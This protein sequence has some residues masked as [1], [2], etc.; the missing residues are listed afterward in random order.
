MKKIII[1]SVLTFLIGGVFFSYSSVLAADFKPSVTIPGFFEA[2]QPYPIKGDTLGTYIK[3][4]YTF[5]VYAGSILAAVMILMAGYS[6]L[7]AGGNVNQIG[8]AKKMLGGALGGF[9]LLLTSWV[10]LNTI[11][12]DLVQFKPFNIQPIINGTSSAIEDTQPCLNYPND[13]PPRPTQLYSYEPKDAVTNC[14]GAVENKTC[15]C[16]VVNDNP[17]G[18]PGPM[19]TP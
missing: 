5:S 3:A 2:G 1:L 14:G 7:T 18:G 16:Q 4:I 17:G 8:Q 12:P 9:V 15:W 13:S 10:L 19:P 6:W 11:N